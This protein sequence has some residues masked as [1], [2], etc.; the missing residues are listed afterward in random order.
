[1]AMTSHP[2]ASWD[3]MQDGS[4]FYRKVEIYSMQWQLSDLSNFIIA[5]ARYGGPFALIRNTSKIVA[6]DRM[7]FTKPQI[8][9]F[10]SSGDLI[11]IIPWDQGKIIRMGWTFDE[12]LVVLN[13]EGSYRIYDLQGDHRQYSLGSEAQE[14]GV[15]DARIHE[16]GLVAMTGNLGLLEIKGWEGGK[17]LTLANSTLNAP[18]HCWSIIPPDQTISRHVE[19]LLAHES[20]ILSV[21][22]L[23]CIDQRL[24]RG[25]FAKLAVSP[26][27]KS[28]ALLTKA[29]LLWVVSSDFQR[30]YSEYDTTREGAN[31]ELP[32]QL[33]WCG[34]DALLL[35]WNSVA[36]LVGPYG[37]T[38]R[39][40]YSSPSFAVSEIDGVRIVSSERCDFLQ[41]VPDSSESVFRPGSASPA[42][43]LFDARDHFDR[44]SAKADESIREIRP[45]LA[46][47]V[48][49]CIDAAGQEIEPYWQRRLL[50]AAAFG[51]AF[52]DLYNPT[53]FVNMGQ[54]L[55]V[56]N[57][58]RYYEVG[59]PI[60]YAQYTHTSPRH[61]INRLTARNRHHLALRISAF[62]RLKPDPVLKH[63]ACAKIVRARAE[64]EGAAGD[65]DDDA[66][67]QLIVSKFEAVDGKEKGGVEGVSYAEIAKKAWDIG[68][69][70]L[71]TKLLDHEP[72]AADQVPLLLNMQQ[73]RVALTKAIDS[74]DTDLVYHVLL[75]LKRR[76]NLGDFFRLVSEPSLVTASN[77]LK[78][79]ARETEREMLKD[80]YY[81]EDKRVDSAVLSLEDSEDKEV[82]ERISAIKTAAKFFSEDADHSFEAKAMDEALRLLVFQQQLEKDSDGQK[83]YVGLSVNETMAACFVNGLAKKADR[84]KADWRVPDKRYWYTKLYA[85][86][87]IRDFDGLDA[88]ARSKRSPIGYEPFV[89]HLASKGFNKQAAAYVSR[90]D[91][92]KRADMF[93]ACGEWRSAAL[94]CKERGDR[95]KLEEL[96]AICPNSLIGRELD[97]ILSTMN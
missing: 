38:L 43:I 87:S 24:S 90:C 44:K 35:T 86:T 95:D 27:G 4:V 10:S 15:I 7:A 31:S 39:Y 91:P 82:T 80:Y 77:L 19:V 33:V 53:D 21:D 6:L 36:L 84:I 69:T 52:L 5:G 92:A 55:K 97:Q 70:N 49:A 25:P 68:R 26:N 37:D 22:N 56:L 64:G 93:V 12:E 42:A 83:K 74:G 45:E 61:L 79:Y 16:S 1:M 29:G 9:L 41:K 96:R 34:N 78:V 88:F 48:D 75:H 60:T 46:A 59:I 58:T 76:L 65:V 89:N 23:E 28:L 81:M 71:A 54:T 63:W 30:S 13:E 73:D 2:T 85:L 62:L 67:C 51:R 32:S 47:A 66:L 14:V 3:A 57:A 40:P 94:E 11:Q 17:P 18:P 50:N 72:R 20:T 8:Q